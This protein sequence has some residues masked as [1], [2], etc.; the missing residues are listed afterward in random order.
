MAEKELYE[1]ELLEEFE[2]KNVIE[3]KEYADRK[4]LDYTIGYQIKSL[5][6]L[7]RKY[8]LHDLDAVITDVDTKIFNINNHIYPDGVVV[9]T[10]AKVYRK[11]KVEE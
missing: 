11:Y 1:M 7:A 9:I 10:R 3:K 5:F 8:M 6:E 2:V 4:L